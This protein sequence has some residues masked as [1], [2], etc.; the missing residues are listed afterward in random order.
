MR[1]ISCLLCL[2]LCTAV[3]AQKQVQYS[4]TK[5]ELIAKQKELLN[6]ISD[7]Q[8]QLDAIK[9]DKKATMGQLRALQ[10]K[11]AQRQNLIATINDE[12]SGIDN[13]IK[14]S[15]KEVDAL[16]KKL[17][18]LKIRYAQSIR[19]AYE[20]RSSYD[21]LAFLFSS[22]DFNDAMRRMK[23]LKTFRD[24][25]MQ[26]VEQ[27]RTTQAQLQHKI[28]SLHS[29]KAQKEELVSTQEQQKKVLVD[30]TNQTNKVIQ[31]L[32]GKESELLKEI[33]KNKKIAARV[34]NA[35]KQVIE[36]EIE[37]ATK[38]AQEE[39]RKKVLAGGK[40][41]VNSKARNVK[42]T[43][44]EESG[45]TAPSNHIVRNH[46]AQTEEQPLLSTPTA[47]ALAANFESNKGRLAWPVDKAYITDHYGSHPH[48]V[49]HQVMINN[50][51][52]DLRT[53]SNA[54][55][56]AVFDGTIS[57]VGYMGD[58]LTVI[59]LHGNFFTVYNNMSAASAKKGDHVSANQVIGTAAN[60]DEGAPMLKFQIWKVSSSNKATSL[61]P[62]V[63]L[64]KA[65]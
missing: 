35:I 37:K 6:E 2:L 55:V 64:R 27:I 54:N 51:G 39:E 41:A 38:L 25:R 48:P 28:G 29:E 7:T 1:F 14:S 65:Q 60:D 50:D 61:N 40:G 58:G 33:D 17:Q 36:R 22:N 43:T 46:Q 19:Y 47:V 12:M 21:M 52:I 45:N 20:T 9:N 59:I 34:N 56:K 23:Y 32:K 5:D 62:E 3:I 16:T 4:M 26:Q 8:K 15:S 44:V 11:L 24:F 18:T 57:S 49:E 31:D 63:W 53:T 42:P 30:E 13:D 10:N